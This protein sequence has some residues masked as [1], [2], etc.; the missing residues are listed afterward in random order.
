M[1]AK[2]ESQK[3]H[4][5][6]KTETQ[7]A[8]KQLWLLWS[9]LKPIS[10]SLSLF[11]KQT[12]KG[13]SSPTPSMSFT[14]FMNLSHDYFIKSNTHTSKCFCQALVVWTKQKWVLKLVENSR[15]QVGV[16]ELI[17]FSSSLSLI[18]PVLKSVHHHCDYLKKIF[19]FSMHICP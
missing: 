1:G 2:K 15:V 11:Q 19:S 4:L 7:L 9:L 16:G 8:E 12:D 14:L 5:L 18:F 3:F 6:L 13:K 17:D 10:I